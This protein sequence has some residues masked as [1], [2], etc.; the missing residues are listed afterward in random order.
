MRAS[1]SCS[2]AS[3]AGVL[4]LLVWACGGE[5]PAA[6]SPRSATVAAAA[7]AVPNSPAA[8]KLLGLAKD[9]EAA[10][11]RSVSPCNDFFQFACGGWMQKTPIPD[12]EATWMKSFSVIR[13]TNEK[14]LREILDGYAAGAGAGEPYA[15][16][17]GE[18]YGSC[19]DEPAI[20]KAGAKPLEADLRAIDALKDVAGIAKLAAA[21]HVRGIPVFFDVGAQQD[22]TDSTKMIGAF[23]QAGIG[24]PDRDYYSKDEGKF[25]E[26]RTKYEAHVAAMLKLLG[27]KTAAADAK[28]VLAIEKQLATAHMSKED[29][30]DPKKVYH[31][32]QK[33]DLKTVAPEFPWDAYL[34]A[35]PLGGAQ[36]FNVAQ[37]SYLMVVG[38]LVAA[39]GG[40]DK[41]KLAKLRAYLKWH[42]V[43]QAAG[44]LSAPFVQENFQW[45]KALVGTPALPPRWKRCVRRTDAALGEA[46]AQPFVK[47][48]L[49]VQG[50]QNTLELVHAIEHEMKAN[51]EAIGWMDKKTKELAFAKLAKIANQIAFPDKWRQYDALKIEKGA[52]FKNVQSANAFEEKR[53]LAKIGKPVDRQEWFMTPPTVNAYYDP[54]MN[55]MVFP[56]G[57]LQ[58]PFYST[59]AHPAANFG[60]I[61]MVMGHE[62]THG[63]D[64]EG[65][66]F[67]AD[68]NLKD[69]WT[70]ETNAEFERRASCVEKQFD[71]YVVL[72]EKI[73]GKLTLGENIADLGGIKLSFGALVQYAKSH[74]FKPE[75]GADGATPEQRFYLGY[76]QAWCGKYRDE[77]MRLLVA[78]NPHSPPQSRVNGPLSNQPSFATAFSCTRGQPMARKDACEVW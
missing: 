36:Q 28:D 35:L 59:A 1:I 43:H 27:S 42:L 46:L 11:D 32:T 67:D 64:D 77:T 78:T 7:V 48:T 54:S 23:D 39:S 44:T 14:I 13:E 34:A 49:G 19:M 51:I 5:S 75:G 8:P 29:R 31:L 4:P 61:G 2:L 69:W 17:L 24:L 40:A 58:P 3:F 50:K 38:Q 76:A 74:P 15:K 41:A 52:F 73:N 63:F 26:L 65:R 33:A 6:H 30:R 47:K 68:G 60:A 55:Q 12:D 66:Q 70:P 18:F 37:P 56:A 9:D 62:L 53:T 71:G 57:I 20:D 16:A 25:P 72:G 45:Q 22:F 21:F 10:L